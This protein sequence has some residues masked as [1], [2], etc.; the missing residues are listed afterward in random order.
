MKR[1]LFT[2][3]MAFL[4]TLSGAVW[5]QDAQTTLTI[6]STN[7]TVTVTSA[8]VTITQEGSEQIENAKIS[9]GGTD[10]TEYNVTINALNLK[11][12]GNIGSGENP[13]RVMDIPNDVT[14]N[15]TVIGENNF[16]S[17]KAAAIFLPNN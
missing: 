5:G 2:F 11:D 1:K 13:G 12:N 6:S 8:D 10:I 4:A 7:P 9:F 15:L 17:E 3:L 14:V 16:Y